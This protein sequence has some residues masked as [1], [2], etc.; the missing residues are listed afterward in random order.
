[1]SGLLFFSHVRK[2]KKEI[3]LQDQ[4]VCETVG[5]S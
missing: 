4:F 5:E 1:M 2:K 3:C